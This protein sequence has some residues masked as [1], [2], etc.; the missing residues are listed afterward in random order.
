MTYE[1]GRSGSA[2]YTLHDTI[3]DVE[4]MDSDYVRYS[5]VAVSHAFFF[6]ARGRR[7][8][9]FSLRIRQNCSHIL[10][11]SRDSFDGERTF[12]NLKDSLGSRLLC[13]SLETA[14]KNTHYGVSNGKKPT[15]AATRGINLGEIPIL[16][17]WTGGCIGGYFCN[18]DIYNN[19]TDHKL[20]KL[21]A[22]IHTEY[23]VAKR[24]G[25]FFLNP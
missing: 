22:I 7:L 25:D 11:S 13:K 18:D 9:K 8:L 10:H 4:M 15:S 12:S 20:R 14:K 23:G 17:R 2:P 6:W 16:G 1:H 19:R 3:L 5:W 21:G 24:Y